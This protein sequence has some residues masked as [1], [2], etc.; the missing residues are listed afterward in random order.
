MQASSA[1]LTEGGADL[2]DAYVAAVNL[3]GGGLASLEASRVAWGW[4][5]R[6]VIEFN[7]TEGSLW[8]DMED[9][10]R[11]PRLLCRLTRP[12]APAASATCS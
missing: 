6:Q 9:L 8:W 10:N 7:G 1:K 12:M 11:L 3:R 4:K 5:G 2:E